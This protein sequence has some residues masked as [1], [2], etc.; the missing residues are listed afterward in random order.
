VAITLASPESRA[1]GGG[2]FNGNPEESQASNATVTAMRTKIEKNS[3]IAESAG[4]G[5]GGGVYT[6]GKFTVDRRL[7]RQL[8]DGLAGNFATTSND[9]V[10][11]ELTL[12]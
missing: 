9:N 11:G 6:V 8:I 2:I 1:Q 12:A 7:Q 5:I 10:F 3:A 4:Q